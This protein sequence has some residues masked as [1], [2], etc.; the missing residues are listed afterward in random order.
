MKVN[1]ELY[2]K[3]L[4]YCPYYTHPGKLGAMCVAPHHVDWFLKMLP[5]YNSYLE[6][7]TFDGI[8]L[9][10]YAST[11][12]EKKFVA[13]DSFEAAYGT[14]GGHVE[15]FIE[16]CKKLDNV[17]LYIG[18]SDVVLPLLTDLFDVIFIDGAHDYVSIRKDSNT[19]WNILN[20]NGIMIF[21]DINLEGTTRAIN[22]LASLTGAI[23]KLVS[24]V[25]VIYMEKE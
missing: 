3:D 17:E 1:R 7:G 23:P 16:N 14:A 9:S 25:G 21:H 8:A 13:I 4:D 22:E 10:I 19:G 20:R 5:K 18:R 12:P 6:I 15:F 24:Q 11:F 2:T